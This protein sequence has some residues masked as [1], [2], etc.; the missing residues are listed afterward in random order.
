MAVV[1]ILQ[2]Q[3]LKH[4]I[5][6]LVH[7]H[8]LYAQEAFLA[9]IKATKPHPELLITCIS[10]PM[11]LTPMNLTSCFDSSGGGSYLILTK[12]STVNDSISKTDYHESS[13]M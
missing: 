1:Y 11:T 9:H 8:N 13:G 6:V 7:T 5:H 10:E 2:N 4:C 12:F 3:V